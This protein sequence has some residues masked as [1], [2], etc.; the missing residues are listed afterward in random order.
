MTRPVIF[1][2]TVA[3]RR[4]LCAREFDVRW[5]QPRNQL[6]LLDGLTDELSGEHDLVCLIL[7]AVAARLRPIGVREPHM[8]NGVWLAFAIEFASADLTEP[9][10][11]IEAVRS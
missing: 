6:G 1:A 7:A 8:Q 2:E 10:G 9:L 4:G 5:Q 11:Q 3:W